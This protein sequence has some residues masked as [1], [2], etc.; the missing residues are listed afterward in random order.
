M[1]LSRVIIDRDNRRK[2][3][4]L[5][6]AGAFHNWVESSFPDEFESQTRSRKLWRIDRIAGIDYLLVVS[7]QK[8]DLEKLEQYGV[9]GSA[10][11][12]PYDQFLD[13]LAEGMVLKFRVVLNPV[14]S[15]VKGDVQ[16]RG[17]V[18]PHVTVEQQMKFLLDRSTKNGF[19]LEEGNFVITNREFVPFRKQNEKEI[20]L[21]KVTYEGRLAISDIDKFK[22][23]LTQGFGKK[24]AYGFGL[25]TVIPER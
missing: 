23:T 10:Q 6:H 13:K 4:D 12:K 19:S 2:I 22:E 1:Y 5:T 16:K 14:V 9:I 17:R 8:P 24:K 25:L 21:S 3:R 18:M 7:P 20:G 11:T 15:R